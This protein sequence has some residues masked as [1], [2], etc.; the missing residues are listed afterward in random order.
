MK[1][2]TL[3]DLELNRRGAKDGYNSIE[4]GDYYKTMYRIYKA[5][6]WNSDDEL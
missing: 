3:D 5:Y 1:I 2:K 4:V 6:M